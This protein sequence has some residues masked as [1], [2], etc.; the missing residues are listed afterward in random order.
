MIQKYWHQRIMS[1][2]KSF[3]SLKFPC[4]TFCSYSVLDFNTWHF[5][6]VDIILSVFLNVQIIY[7]ST[8]LLLLCV[9]IV[10]C[11]YVVPVV[12]VASVPTGPNLQP[13]HAALTQ[14]PSLPHSPVSPTLEAGDETRPHLNSSTVHFTNV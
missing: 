6:C 12:C 4:P 7:F 8:Y 11:W 1:T 2:S 5:S 9:G 10:Y 13:P 14:S 3:Q